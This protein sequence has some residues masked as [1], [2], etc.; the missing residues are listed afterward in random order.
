MAE[1]RPPV[2]PKKLLEH[3]M[4]WEKGESTP[5]KVLSDLKRA[6]MR[7]FLESSATD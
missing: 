7:E 6:G 5:G 2:E 1:S 4:E 3:W